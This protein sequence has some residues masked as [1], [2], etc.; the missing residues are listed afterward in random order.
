[1]HNH[2]YNAADKFLKTL[3]A[4]PTGAGTALRDRDFCSES[5]RCNTSA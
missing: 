4:A 2:A 3:D 1:M 5:A